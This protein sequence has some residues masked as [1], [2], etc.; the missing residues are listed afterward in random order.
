MDGR[1][2]DLEENL[3]AVFHAD[4][5]E[6]EGD[7]DGVAGDVKRVF[8]CGDGVGEVVAGAEGRAVGEGPY[9]AGNFPVVVVGDIVV[10]GASACGDEDVEE[11]ACFFGDAVGGDFEGDVVAVV[12]DADGFD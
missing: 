2:A 7:F 6:R 5:G 3:A 4:E 8:A 9:D 11:R 10:A 12:G 1:V